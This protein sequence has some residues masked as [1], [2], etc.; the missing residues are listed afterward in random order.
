MLGKGGQA[1]WGVSGYPGPAVT[2]D[3]QKI[4]VPLQV[5]P[6]TLMKLSI[7]YIF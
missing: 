1:V 7:P 5:G 4:V 3:S 2:T 6:P